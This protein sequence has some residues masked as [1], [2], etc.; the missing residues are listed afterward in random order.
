MVFGGVHA[1]SLSG[2]GLELGGA[3]A[4]VKGDGD[5]IWGEALED[6]ASSNPRRLYDGGRIEADAF[7]RRAGS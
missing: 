3:H 1:T 2:R 7:W 5:V 6:C 4:V